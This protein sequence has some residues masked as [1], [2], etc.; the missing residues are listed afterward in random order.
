MIRV[1]IERV[2]LEGL[3]L[4]PGGIDRLRAAMERELADALT[5]ADAATGDLGRVV[6]GR[7]SQA[8][9][10]AAD[11]VFDGQSP[12]GSGQGLARSVAAALTAGDGR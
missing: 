6:A 12:A 11:V 5:T 1:H 9:L 3:A 4:A 10:A 7:G 2:V 8:R